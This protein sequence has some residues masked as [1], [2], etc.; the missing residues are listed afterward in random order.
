[1]NRYGSSRKPLR[2]LVVDD[3]PNVA[4]SLAN[5]LL[6]KESKA[7]PL[8]VDDTGAIHRFEI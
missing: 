2:V 7:I 1:M 5:V 6:E 3:Y 4:D 8:R